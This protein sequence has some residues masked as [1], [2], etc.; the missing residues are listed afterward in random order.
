MN[1]PPLSESSLPFDPAALSAFLEEKWH[2]PTSTYRVQFHGGFGFRDAADVVPYLDRLGIDA[3][4]CSPYLQARPGTQHGYDICDYDRLHAELGSEAD[5]DAFTDALAQAGMGQIVDFVPNHMGV[6]PVANRWWRDVLENG[7]SSPFAHFFDIDWDPVKAELRGKVLLPVL[8]DHYGLVLERGELQLAFNEGRFLVTNGPLNFPVD[9]KQSPHVLQYRLDALAEQLGEEHPDLNTFRELIQTFHE[10]PGCS[11]TDRSE[12]RRQLMEDL[13]DRL[14]RLVQSNADIAR[15][16]DENVRRFNGEPGVRD[17][18]DL[19]HEFLEAQ[20]YRLAWWK[21]AHDEINYRRFFHIQELGG[22]RMEDGEVFEAA[23]RLILR[24]IRQGRVT[25]IR[26]DHLDG[27]SDPWHYLRKLQEAVVLARATELFGDALLNDPEVQW[28]VAEWQSRQD[29]EGIA[30][31]PLYVVAEKIL[32]SHESLPSYWPLHGTS[33]YDFMNDL[34]RLFVDHEHRQEMHGI[35]ERFTGDRQP[36]EEVVEQCKRLITKQ[37]LASEL[38][39]L[40]RALNRIAELDRRTRDF[41]LDSLREA[42]REVVVAFP[43]YRTYIDDCGIEPADREIINRAVSRAM[44]R[45]PAL[46]PSVFAFLH[47]VLLL[48]GELTEDEW[49]RR[50]EFVMK[51][52]QYTGPVEAKGVEDTAFYRDNVLLSLNEVGGKPDR[53]GGSVDEFHEA[54]RRRLQEWPY[55]MLATATHD[56]KRG[57]DVRARINIL[58]EIPDEWERHVSRWHHLHAAHRIDL[59]GLPAPSPADEY[60]FYQTLLGAWPA[61]LDIDPSQPIPEK[62]VQRMREFLLK[63]AREASRFTG[64]MHPVES[65]EEAVAGFVDQVLTGPTARE[66][67]ENFLPF[68]RQVARWGMINSLAQV[69]LKI[70]SPGVPDFYQGSELW[71]LNLVDPDNRRPVDY[72]HRRQLL[73]QL[74]PLLNEPAGDDRPA[75]VAELLEQ[76]PDGRIKLFVTACGLR[77][78]RRDPSL[79]LQGDSLPLNASGPLEEHV[80]AAGRMREDRLVIAVAPRMVTRLTEAAGSNPIR[81]D[82]WNDTLLRLPREFARQPLRNVFTGETVELHPTNQDC[83]LPVAKLLPTLPVALLTAGE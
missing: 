23:H 29:P 21:A 78:R 5:Y 6:D 60:A 76:W 54:N 77:L 53:F 61:G 47:K 12:E 65:Y 67:L 1:D 50:L 26:L 42:I 48:E 4:Y 17:S 8:S 63:A 55:A 74:E 18:F 52:Q 32:A 7:P 62:F 22:L 75:A 33:G 71:D 20:P 24:L 38:K 73:E 9:P 15:H 56:N 46:S 10:L 72:P 40:A 30:E 69:V 34:N 79:F 13:L 39:M 11:E 59:D 16:V 44:R 2:V 70:I 45:N 43:V 36:Y 58:S 19:L 81:P 3:C 51:F 68:Q 14:D 37:A 27:L 64:W 80:V 82:V 31:R 25:G 41:T 49:E 57:E 83:V 66:F 28:E 35:Y